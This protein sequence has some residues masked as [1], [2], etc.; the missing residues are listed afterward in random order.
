MIKNIDNLYNDY[1]FNLQK[2]FVGT[3]LITAYHTVIN[4]P[5][6]NPLTHNP[7]WNR[8]YFVFLVLKGSIRFQLRNE[9]IILR[10]NEIMFGKTGEDVILLDD[11]NQAEFLAF[12]FQLFNYDLPLFK[13]YPHTHKQ[14]DITALH[15]MLK[16][17]RMKSALGNGAANAAFCELLFGWLHKI[18]SDAMQRVPHASVMLDAELFINEH[19]EEKITVQSLAKQY[20]FS[21]KHFRTLFTKVIGTP[22]KKYIDTVKLERAYTL[23]KT[24]S[25]PITQIAN[26]L[27][28]SSWRH[29]TISFKNTYHITPS[30]CRQTP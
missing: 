24:T 27:Q 6:C 30:V 29:F 15:K 25:M 10:E 16:G 18:R 20:N 5:Y 28:F 12:H 13:K 17:L 8:L 3:N 1:A 9:T 19:V 26:K 7:D 11:K 14:K 23:L 2:T 22:P 21:E 4:V